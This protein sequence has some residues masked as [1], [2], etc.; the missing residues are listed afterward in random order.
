MNAPHS[1]QPGMPVSDFDPFDEGFLAEPYEQLR[2]LRDLGPVVHLSRYGIYA[3]ARHAEVGPGLSNWQDFSSARGVGIDDFRKTKPRR[4]ASILLEVDPP[5]HTR[6]RTVMQRV[7]SPAAIKAVRDAYSG[8]VDD[9]VDGLVRRGRF[10]GVTDLA[11]PVP[12][13]IFPDAVG[14]GE[15]GRENLLP[16][17]NAVFNSFGPENRLFDEANRTIQPVIAWILS[18]CVREAVKPGGFGA[19]IYAAMDAGEI[20]ADEAPVLV[21]SML[22]AGLDTTVNGIGNTLLAFTRFPD[23][24]QALRDDPSLVKAAFDESLRYES[25]VQTFFRT[26]NRDV[27][28]AGHL[29]PADSKALF[30]LASANRDERKWPEP[31]RFDIRRRPIGHVAFGNGIHACVGQQIARME[32]ELVLSALVRRAA[33]IEL[34]GEPVRRLNNTVRGLA[35][36]PLKVT[37]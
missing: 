11:E 32:A 6:T 2:A 23:Q 37:A 27:E 1:P 25:P 28:I 14:I 17:S 20:D 33:R 3:M 5:Y 21:R 29:V 19:A 34:D 15:E 36:L 30:F 31:E 22:T 9:W 4:P 13:K 26:T 10:D 24:W 8:F 7:L 16:F 12:L 35:S 18:Q